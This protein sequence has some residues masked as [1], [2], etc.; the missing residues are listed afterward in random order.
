L[1]KNQ[2]D[3][4]PKSRANLEDMHSRVKAAR[5]SGMRQLQRAIADAPANELKKL[6]PLLEI[7]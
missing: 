7:L 6:V 4:L 5:V 2:D 3:Q 1:Y